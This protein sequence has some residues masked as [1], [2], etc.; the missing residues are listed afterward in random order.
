MPCVVNAH[1]ALARADGFG[2][3]AHAFVP[4]EKE[5]DDPRS[6]P[7]ADRNRTQ[8]NQTAAVDPHGWDA[9]AWNRALCQ[10]VVAAHVKMATHARKYHAPALP[11]ET[12]YAMWPRSERL[13]AP[14]PPALDPD[15]RA[16]VPPGPPPGRARAHP[17][18]ELLIRPIIRE[19]SEKALFRSL[20]GGGA[21]GRAMKPSDGYFLP[22]GF[23]DGSFL[24]GSSLPG[25]GGGGGGG[26]SSSFARPRPKA[27]A[28]IAKHF[29]VLDAPAWIRGEP[30]RRARAARTRS[31]NSPRRCGALRETLRRGA[32]PPDAAETHVELSRRRRT[33]G[34]R[35]TQRRPETP[36]GSRGFERPSNDPPR[37]GRDATRARPPEDSLTGCRRMP[38]P[39]RRPAHRREPRG[40]SP[41]RDARRTRPS[42]SREAWARRP[43]R[44][45]PPA[46]RLRGEGHAWR[47]RADGGRRRRRAGRGGRLW[48]GTVVAALGRTSSRGSAP[49]RRHASNGLRTTFERT[50][51]GRTT[52]TPPLAS[53]FARED[54]SALVD[55]RPFTKAQLAA[56]L[57]RALP[58]RLNPARARRAFEPRVD[59]NVDPNA[60]NASPNAREPSDAWLAAFWREMRDDLSD[61]TLALFGAW[62]LLPIRGDALARVA[63]RG[64]VF[65]A[66]DEAEAAM[67]LDRMTERGTPRPH[68]LTPGSVASDDDDDSFQ[69]EAGDSQGEATEGPE[70][71]PRASDS[72]S[73][74]GTLV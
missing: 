70:R 43:R 14:R 71:D 27:A 31:A 65:V 56:E 3:E 44:P 72:E 18:S 28:F 13:G 66:P 74:S 49:P 58:P 68:P 2:R 21:G 73:S 30:R 36:R 4:G 33:C 35:R 34:K 22:A 7:N 25:G 57:P 9:S 67:D 41:G 29:P 40:N 53:L 62:P 12:F 16:L 10:C 46:S 55:V 5:G 52:K 59:P 48:T 19:L 45:P 6:A 61:E 39:A 37:G 17:A 8:P 69:H 1:F 50:S 54:F 26:G 20:G 24:G 23:A 47:S 51:N 64:A 32:R 38:P 11:S 42:R 15:G 63:H 60:S